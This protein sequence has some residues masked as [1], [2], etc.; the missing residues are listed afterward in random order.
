[1]VVSCMLPK[2]FGNPVR[3]TQN[4]IDNDYRG[5]TEETIKPLLAAEGTV[6]NLVRFGDGIY[7]LANDNGIPKTINYIQNGEYGNAALSGV[8]DVINGA[9]TFVGGKGLRN[10]WHRH[11]FTQPESTVTSFKSELDWNPESWFGT[12][13]TGAYDAEDVAALKAHIPEYYAI[14]EEAKRNG[15]WLKM[16][17]GSTWEGDPRSWVQLQSKD[18]QK[19]M[20]RP[21]YHGDTNVYS[22]ID[23]NDVTPE[24]LGEG[25]LWTSSNKH[26]PLTYGNHHYT[27]TIPKNTQMVGINTEGRNWN[28]LKNL[29]LGYN[30]TNDVSWNLLNNDNVVEIKML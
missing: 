28:N 21:F 11:D 29:N 22:D 15:T 25:V 18:G 24:K 6:G 13:V 23:G 2:I 30:N 3:L 19:L 8:G 17:D 5:A 16:P 20:Q 26:L 10:I 7:S 4:L 12:R 9:L 14:E 27:L 1:M